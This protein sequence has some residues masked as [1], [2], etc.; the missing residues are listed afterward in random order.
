MRSSQ[1]S[2]IHL[3]H[4]PFGKQNWGMNYD[5]CIDKLDLK[6]PRGN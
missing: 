5:Q 6:L 2:G 4:M 3:Q 1:S